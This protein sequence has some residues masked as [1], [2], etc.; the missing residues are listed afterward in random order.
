MNGK[1]TIANTIINCVQTWPCDWLPSMHA[2]QCT[3]SGKDKTVPHCIAALNLSIWSKGIG[4][5]GF[6]FAILDSGFPVFQVD[7]YT[8]EYI[9]NI[10]I[11]SL[12]QKP[13]Q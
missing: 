5:Q 3:L 13:E 12:A 6:I 1:K 2:H 9:M 8:N 4:M 7:E 10:L 11:I